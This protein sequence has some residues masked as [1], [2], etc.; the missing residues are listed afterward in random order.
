MRQVPPCRRGCT[1]VRHDRVD[2]E[3]SDP[4][5]QDRRECTGR[6]QH[7]DGHGQG[8]TR[9]PYHAEE[10]CEMSH[11]RE[12]L[13]YRGKRL[14][15]SV[16]RRVEES[17]HER[18][19]LIV[20]RVQSPPTCPCER[21]PPTWLLTVQDDEG[22]SPS[23]PDHHDS[24]QDESPATMA[25][26]RRS[27]RGCA[28]ILSSLRPLRYGGVTHYQPASSRRRD[29]PASSRSATNSAMATS[30]NRDRRRVSTGAPVTKRYFLQKSL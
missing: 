8:R 13:R 22:K 30:N 19:P 5:R 12:A 16:P 29:C 17:S 20:G 18:H 7:Y 25:G 21:R 2:N 1:N 23:R 3:L 6:S 14:P 26:N 28:R 27:I 9:R 11:R 15:V 10:R 4:E 24:S